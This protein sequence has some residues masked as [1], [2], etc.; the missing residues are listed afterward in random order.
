ML[1][2]FLV[3]VPFHQL[4]RRAIQFFVSCHL[5]EL[6]SD[7][8]FGAQIEAMLVF[9]LMSPSDYVEMYATI[10][11]CFEQGKHIYHLLIYVMLQLGQNDVNAFVESLEILHR[12]SNLIRRICSVDCMYNSILSLSNSLASRNLLK[13]IS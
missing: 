8:F 13:A 3:K 1:L 6:I 7:H 5:H 10:K 9:S 2:H 4:Q 11:D 12:L